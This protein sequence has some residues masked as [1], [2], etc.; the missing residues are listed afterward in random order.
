MSG[1][2]SFIQLVPYWN[3]IIDGGLGVC[4]R[5]FN[6]RRRG[7]RG[8]WN[9]SKTWYNLLLCKCLPTR[10]S[11]SKYTL[12]LS[13]SSSSK[14]VQQAGETGGDIPINTPNIL[15]EIVSCNLN[16]NDYKKCENKKNQTPLMEAIHI[17]GNI[18]EEEIRNESGRKMEVQ[19]FKRLD[20]RSDDVGCLAP[21]LKTP[22]FLIP[23][24]DILASWQSKR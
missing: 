20:S 16:N 9:R 6:W 19:R 8:D 14:I 11:S 2:Y 7:I 22:T 15:L 12:S 24:Y 21:P 23:R 5:R 4:Y 18:K 17:V 1:R 13:I 10:T 3:W